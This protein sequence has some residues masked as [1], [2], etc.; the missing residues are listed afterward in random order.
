MEGVCLVRAV[1]GKSLFGFARA[2]GR[3]EITSSKS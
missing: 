1:R 2:E 3:L